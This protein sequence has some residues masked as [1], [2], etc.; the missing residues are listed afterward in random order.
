MDHHEE[1]DLEQ[2]VFGP[3][4]LLNKDQVF[5]E[6]YQKELAKYQFIYQKITN[7]DKR[8]KEVLEMIEMI[9]KVLQ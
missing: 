3:I 6:Y 5:K 4:L 2:I 7:D 1:Y 8:K 9:Q